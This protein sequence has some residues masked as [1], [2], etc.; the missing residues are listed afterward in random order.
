MRRSVCIAVVVSL[1]FGPAVSDNRT[2]WIWCGF[3]RGF[4]AEVAL[5]AETIAAA[6]GLLLIKDWARREG[7]V[8]E[9]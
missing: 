3:F 9:I 5:A 1:F 7:Y 2:A 4:A 6:G 8:V